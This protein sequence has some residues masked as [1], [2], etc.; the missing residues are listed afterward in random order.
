MKVLVLGTL[1]TLQR[2]RGS[3]W[4]KVWPGYRVYR[5]EV[6][7]PLR[8]LKLWVR[9]KRRSRKLVCSGCGRKLAEAYDT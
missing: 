9:R 5:H 7:E 2:M 4:S 3:D 8:T 6:N 1:V